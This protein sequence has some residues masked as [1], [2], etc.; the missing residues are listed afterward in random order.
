MDATRTTSVDWGGYP[1]LRFSSVPQAIEVHIIS[2]LGEPFLGTGESAQGPAGAALA[3]AVADATGARLREIP[4][5]RQR[6]RTA[7]G[8]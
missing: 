2:R 1:I 4:F 3:N 7:V 5:T 6:V 8:A